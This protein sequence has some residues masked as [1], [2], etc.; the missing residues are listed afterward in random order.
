MNSTTTQAIT[1][2]PATLE[3]YREALAQAQA[4]LA[5]LRAAKP[6]R[7]PKAEKRPYVFTPF[8]AHKVMNDERA[9]LGLPPVTPQM[10]Y[11][12]ARKGKFI[13]GTSEDGRKIVD[14][15]TFFTWMRAFNA[16]NS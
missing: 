7:A 8:Q 1:T 9:D 2:G 15:D 10:L 4:E 13:T 5:A 11:S 16:K 14:P 12:Y 3:N 6:V